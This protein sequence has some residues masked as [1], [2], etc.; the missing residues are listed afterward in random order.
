MRRPLNR[1]AV[2]AVW[3]Q[4]GYLTRRSPPLHPRPH[5]GGKERMACSPS[6]GGPHMR[7][8][9]II[10]M[11]VVAVIVGAALPTLAQQPIEEGKRDRA[12]TVPGGTY[13]VLP[14]TL[15]TTQW[16]W[17]DPKESPK[18]VVNSG[19]TVAIET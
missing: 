11:A 7:R 18:L 13:H 12:I 1:I 6:R 4:R 9:F 14:A 10:V 2:V 15:E 19:D 3:G 16:G 17:L 5:R 8:I